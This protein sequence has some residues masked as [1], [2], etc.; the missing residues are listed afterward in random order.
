MLLDAKLGSSISPD[1]PP[2]PA[3]STSGTPAIGCGFK[4]PSSIILNEPESS[5]NRILLLSITAI[6]HG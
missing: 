6:A 1:K 4:T 3:N 2:W 5:V